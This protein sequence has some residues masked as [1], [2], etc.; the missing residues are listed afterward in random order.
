MSR[1]RRSRLLPL[2]AVSLLATGA[3][4]ACGGQDSGSGGERLR[5]AMAFPP[6]QGMSPYGDDA[7]TLSRLSVIEGLTR[8][9]SKG[10]VKPALATSWKPSDGGKEW[11]FTLRE[12]RFQDGDPVNAD[13]V[14]RSL[15]EAEKA[16]PKPRVL[17]DAGDL[18]AEAEGARKVRVT[19]SEPDALLPQ[20]L[21]NPSL[22][23]LSA[24]AYGAADT[25]EGGKGAKGSG[26]SEKG[27]RV[28]PAGHAT[29]PFTLTRLNGTA[30]ATL[31]RNG[32]YWGDKAEAPGVDVKFVSDGTARAN[33]LRGGQT[34]IAEYVPVSQASV[35]D[36]K[37]VHEV[38]TARTNSLYLNTERGV[39]KDAGM[40]ATVREAVD[41]KALIKGVYEGRADTPRGLFGPGVSWAQDKRVKVS[42]RADAA[43]EKDVKATKTITLATYTNRP[44]LPEVATVLQ[45]QLRKAGFKVKQDVRDYAQMEADA[46][47]GKYDAFLQAR[48]TLLDTGDPVSYL[49]SDFTCDGSFNISQLCDGSVDS[50]V[51]K[52]AGTADTEKR[53]HAEMRAEARVLGTDAVVPLLH[54]RFV[55]GVADGVEGVSFD[56]MERTLVT[57]DTRRG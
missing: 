20:R 51:R 31:E 41:S 53:Q 16:S 27:G 38:P 14:V 7:V 34:D 6:A 22:A 11:T 56:P 26:S 4:T 8:L 43:P 37:Q 50:A 52:A 46:L 54:E 35:L 32:T 12:A 2:A 39:F 49:Q 24:G 44:E 18:K 23:V 29:G 21:A 36:E 42:G 57:A 33:A 10:E 13:A 9:D 45:Q 25:S 48:N 30:S 17:S 1:I 15:E 55:Q 40:R 47:S 19:S 3:L 5:V 28:D